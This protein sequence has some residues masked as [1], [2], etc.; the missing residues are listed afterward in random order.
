MQN[1]FQNTEVAYN[2]KKTSQIRKSIFLFSL[3]TKGFFFHFSER[4]PLNKLHKVPNFIII[5]IQLK[6]TWGI[7]QFKFLVNFHR[8]FQSSSMKIYDVSFSS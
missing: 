1:L 7:R 3:L 2:L 6:Q 5:F 4:N 8:P